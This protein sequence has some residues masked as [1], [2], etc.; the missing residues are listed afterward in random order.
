MM[1]FL[2]RFSQ[3]HETFRMPEIQ[4]LALVAGVEMR[5]IFYDVEVSTCDNDPDRLFSPS[6]TSVHS[7]HFALSNFLQKMLQGPSSSALSWP[8]ASM[9]T[10]AQV[11]T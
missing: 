2:I 4:A 11:T 6:L 1:E 10:G 8:K 5:V 7:H 9:S 3:S